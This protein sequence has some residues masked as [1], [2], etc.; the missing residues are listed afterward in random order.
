M[1][2]YPL[3]KKKCR[4]YVTNIMGVKITHSLLSKPLVNWEVKMSK[5]ESKPAIPRPVWTL[6]M[7]E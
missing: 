3:M 5:L 6:L 1:V 4:Y 7:G 2:Y